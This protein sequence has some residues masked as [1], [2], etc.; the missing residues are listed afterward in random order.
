MKQWKIAVS[1]A[2]A[3]PLTAP[4]LMIGDV[5]SNLR[6]AGALGFQAIEVHTREDAVLDYEGIA[7]AAEESGCKVGMIITGRLNT[8]GK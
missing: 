2:D 5:A 1:S 3:A 4:I 7:K 8:E 6:K